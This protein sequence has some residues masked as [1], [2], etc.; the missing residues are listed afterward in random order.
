MGD[1]HVALQARLMGQAM[2]LTA[3]IGK[4]KTIVIFINQIRMKIG[5]MFGNPETTP[6]GRALKFYASVRLDIRR[7]ASI[8]EGDVIT[9]NHVKVKV[10][11]NK[12]AAPFREAEFDIMFDSGISAGRF[13]R[14]G[15]HRQ[16]HRQI[17]RLVELQR[18][19]PGA[20][21]RERQAVPPGQ[22]GLSRGNPVGRAG[23]A[24]GAARPR[25]SPRP[26]KAKRP[27][28]PKRQP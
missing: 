28:I 15:R 25:P 1:T 2:Q 11:K 8:K 10:V 26:R 22:P 18:S 12:V 14:P 13:A 19:P 20:G 16:R 7:I 23:E 27:R 3:A 21:S 17:R 24:S 4:T 6:G 5:V 9:G